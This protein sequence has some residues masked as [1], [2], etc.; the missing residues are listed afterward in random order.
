MET[1]NLKIVENDEIVAI[2]CGDI[3]ID[4]SGLKR[5]GKSIVIVY[6]KPNTAIKV[7][8]IEAKGILAGRFVGPNDIFFLCAEGIPPARAE[9]YFFEAKLMLKNKGAVS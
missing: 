5:K 8:R 7:E 2:G 4:I 9:E 3:N 6:E 1:R